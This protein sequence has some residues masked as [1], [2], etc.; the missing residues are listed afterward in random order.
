MWKLEPVVLSY[1]LLVNLLCE[2]SIRDGNIIAKLILI[3]D[4]ITLSTT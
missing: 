2:D 4:H 3:E 1:L